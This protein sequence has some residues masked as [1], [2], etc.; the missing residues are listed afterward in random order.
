MVEG[1]GNESTREGVM[2]TWNFIAFLDALWVCS[3]EVFDAQCLL[4]SSLFLSHFKT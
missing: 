4:G 1:S 3:F 2:A